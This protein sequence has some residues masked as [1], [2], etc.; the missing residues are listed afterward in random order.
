MEVVAVWDLYV[1]LSEP[2]DHGRTLGPVAW[3]AEA[4]VAPRTFLLLMVLVGWSW[5]LTPAPQSSSVP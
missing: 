2:K 4:E 1:A 3:D 5:D